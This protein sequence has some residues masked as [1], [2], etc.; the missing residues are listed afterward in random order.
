M[1]HLQAATSQQQ[2]IPMKYSKLNLAEFKQ[3]KAND[4]RN[5]LG[6]DLSRISNE[7]YNI[8]TSDILNPL[9]S[10]INSNNYLPKHKQLE[11]LLDSFI[12]LNTFCNLL[13]RK[14]YGLNEKHLFEKMVAD[15]CA[16]FNSIVV[17][18]KTPLVKEEL[19]QQL[20]ILN[21]HTHGYKALNVIKRVGSIG[22]I[23]IDKDNTRAWITGAD[24]YTEITSGFKKL[25][26]MLD[27][28]ET[29]NFTLKEE[30]SLLLQ[31]VNQLSELLFN[32]KDLNEPGLNT[33]IRIYNALKMAGV[34][35]HIPQDFIVDRNF[36]SKARGFIL[37]AFSKNEIA[38]INHEAIIPLLKD[39]PE[40]VNEEI[41]KT[42][43][44]NVVAPPLSNHRDK[45]TSIIFERIKSHAASS[46]EHINDV[47]ATFGH[48]KPKE[49]LGLIID[50]KITDFR[51][52][53]YFFN[54]Y[55]LSKDGQ[56]LDKKTIERAAK[57][58]LTLPLISNLDFE[59]EHKV[60]YN[61]LLLGILNALKDKDAL[62]K[63][64]AIGYIIDS[65]D[66]KKAG[67]PFTLQ[68][69]RQLQSTET[70]SFNTIMFNNIMDY[71]DKDNI[72][73]K[74]FYV[75][76]YFAKLQ[77]QDAFK[78]KD[79]ALALD[80][81]R[82]SPGLFD[83]E[84][85]A[86]FLGKVAS[87]KEFRSAGDIQEIV[88]EKRSLFQALNSIKEDFQNGKNE[89]LSKLKA[90]LA[91]QREVFYID[92]GHASD[93]ARIQYKDYC[94]TF[95]N[96]EATLEELFSRKE[97]FMK[98]L[99]DQKRVGG[100]LPRY[101]DIKINGLPADFTINF[102]GNQITATPAIGQKA[103]S[104]IV[105]ALF[106]QQFI[107]QEKAE[108]KKYNEEIKPHLVGVVGNDN[109]Q[110]T[111]DI[112]S[113]QKSRYT[114][115]APITGELYD[116][117]NKR[118]E[119]HARF[120]LDDYP[121]YNISTMY[122]IEEATRS[123]DVA[124]GEVSYKFEIDG[125]ISPALTD[126]LSVPIFLLN[127]KEYELI[128]RPDYFK[129]KSNHSEVKSQASTD[130][131]YT[132]EKID[133]NK[134]SE[135]IISALNGENSLATVKEIHKEY[136]EHFTVAANQTL[137]DIFKTTE[138]GLKLKVLVMFYRFQLEITLPVTE[139]DSILN[140][141]IDRFKEQPDKYTYNIR[142]ILKRELKFHEALSEAAIA[143]IN[144]ILAE[145]AKIGEGEKP[146]PDSGTVAVTQASTRI[147]Q[148]VRQGEVVEAVTPASRRKKSL[149]RIAE[150]STME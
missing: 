49:I 57:F 20:L 61:Q 102:V 43:L 59:N 66:W 27:M 11:G 65:E 129:F 116:T 77:L 131:R 19:L 38:K 94:I 79:D 17:N 115:S 13:L 148:R 53:K 31:E 4:V 147:E 5:H 104:E 130:I 98:I 30:Q 16:N 110:V 123:M 134:I 28:E 3:F 62:L 64:K 145:K 6:V 137:S 121:A 9:V 29:Q 72:A 88:K 36:Y 105:Y 37:N 67:T 86:E 24:K 126:A 68:V 78:L 89:K 127:E 81:I 74:D 2:I 32:N 114:L 96:E 1:K 109:L 47:I 143:K 107:C 21:T 140:N 39:H 42:L 22:F 63:N 34:E 46:T 80:T 142:R 111:L 132:Y 135:D 97:N 8:F 33:R 118:V 51:I 44:I 128:Q 100:N 7:L 91:T 15:F 71:L 70:D 93:K 113:D 54:G 122:E 82:R 99:I 139:Q 83:I 90:E 45:V 75:F 35:D 101:S 138:D 141:I 12:T 41:A 76:R 92:K 73:T 87:H 124:T 108:T 10:G 48:E 103:L 55:L 133:T 85:Q 144:Q 60:S 146:T 14:D 58:M 95:S 56:L 120:V 106:S 84:R 69:I 117:I 18:K 125:E 23:R 149:K 40:L 136:H 112:N 52:I 119:R 150:I 26:I 25:L 50:R